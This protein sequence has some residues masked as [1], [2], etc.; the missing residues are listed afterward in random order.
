MKIGGISNTIL[1]TSSEILAT[2]TAL[3]TQNI[4]RARFEGLWNQQVIQNGCYIDNTIESEHED[5]IVLVLY[6]KIP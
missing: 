1:N 4:K 3:F 2:L 6:W 5:G